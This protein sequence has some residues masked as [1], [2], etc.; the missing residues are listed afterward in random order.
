MEIIED[1]FKVDVKK[2]VL[3]R[4]STSR[5]PQNGKEF[6]VVTISRSLKI[7]RTAVYKIYSS[8]KDEKE[9]SDQIIKMVKVIRKRMP[10]I[11]CLKLYGLLKPKLEESEIKC[12]RDKLFKI[13]RD[14]RMLVPKKKKFTRTTQ[15]NHLFNKHSNQVKGVCLRRPP[16]LIMLVHNVKWEHYR[17][18]I[19][20][21]SYP[22]INL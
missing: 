4:L 16:I 5:T 8:L 21:S 9:I 6:Q 1:E 19:V 10:R 20:V 12:G 22:L 2:K 7:S 13:L 14:A 18:Y 11:G 17:I 3:N 15:S